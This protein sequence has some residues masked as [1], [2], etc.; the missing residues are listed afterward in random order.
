MFWKFS[1]RFWRREIDTNRTVFK[2][3][4]PKLHKYLFFYFIDLDIKSLLFT[5]RG[6]DYPHSNPQLRKY[7]TWKTMWHAWN[8]KTRS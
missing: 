6:L 5:F 3:F 7:F 8:I 1:K 2:E 4:P